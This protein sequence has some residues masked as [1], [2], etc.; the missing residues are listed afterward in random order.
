VPLAGREEEGTS[1]PG[2]IPSLARTVRRRRDLF[3]GANE[4]GRNATRPAAGLGGPSAGRDS[5]VRG[6]FVDT[7]GNDGPIV[8]L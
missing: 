1:P 4:V 8:G 3:Y 5:E 2:A 7:N 6:H